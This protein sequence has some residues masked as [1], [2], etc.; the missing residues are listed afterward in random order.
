MV[1]VKKRTRD[2]DIKK[3]AILEAA[4][5]IFAEKGVEKTRIADIAKRANVAYGLVYHYYKNRDEILEKLF[6]THWGV[7][8][9]QVEKIKNEDLSL[10]EKLRKILSF[11]LSVYLENPA[12]I[13]LIIFEVARGSRL[14]LKDQIQRFRALHELIRE[15]FNLAKKKSEIGPEQHPEL[16][17]TMF[18][19]SF[20]GVL[21]GMIMR[22]LEVNQSVFDATVDNF[23]KGVL[24]NR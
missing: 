21:T 10:E 20:E 1:E 12:I 17:A 23:L 2:K 22:V 13:K 9:F 4:V 15:I 3:K 16:L 18:T 8:L 11:L 6:E 19:S 7:F 24:I 5:E 14:L